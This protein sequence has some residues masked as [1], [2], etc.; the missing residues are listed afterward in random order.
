MKRRILKL[1]VV[2]A[3]VPGAGSLEAQPVITSQPASQAVWLGSNVTLTVAVAG[4]GPFAYNWQFNGTNL[5]SV[6]S[7]VAGGG[8]AGSLGDGGAATNAYLTTPQGVAVDLSGALFIADAS[9]N[10]IRKVDLNGII[11]TVAGGGSGGD[12]G[13]ATNASLHSPSGLAVGT[14]GA[15]YIADTWNNRIRM[16][17]T[18]G[19]ITTVAGNG[20]AGR[21]GDGAAATSASLNAPQGVAID[22]FGNLFIADTPNYRIRKVDGGGTITTVAGSGSFGGTGDGG[23]ATNARLRT[24]TGVAVDRSGNLFIADK[25]NSWIRKVDTNGIITRVAGNTEH[26]SGDWGQATNAGLYYPFGVTVDTCGNLY[27]ADTYDN[28]IRK[29]DTNGIIT[30]VAGCGPSE[31]SSGNYSGDGGAATNA[32]LSS[33]CSVALDAVGN[34]YIADQSNHRIRKVAG[35]PTLTLSNV[36]VK[37]VGSYAVVITGA[38]GSVTSSVAGVGLL[39]TPVVLSQ[40]ANQSVWAGSN[41]TFTVTATSSLPMGYQWCGNG[42]GPIAGGTN[43][44]LL[45]NG[46]STNASGN[47]SV[48]ITNS[49]GSIT[50][51]A[52]ALIVNELATQPANQTVLAG[53][54]L[55]LSVGVVGGGPLRFQWQFNGTNLPNN[56]ICTVA[57]QSSAG[58]SGDGG[59]ATN[60]SLYLPGR[61]Q[62]DRVGNLLIPDTVNNRVRKVDTNGFITTVAGNGTATDSGDGGAAT[63]ASLYL[64]NDV[65]WDTAGNMYIGDYQR[66]RKVN[67]NGIIAT[68]TSAVWNASG[69]SMDPSDG[70][71]I[72][73]FH[74]N[75]VSR[76][77][78]NGTLTTVAGPGSPAFLNSPSDVLLDATGN[79]YITDSGNHRVRKVDTHG[80]V[81][82]VAGN[83]QPGYSGD[84]GP[85]T[86]ASLYVSQALTMDAQGNLFIADS[87]N[88]RVREVDTNGII[89]TVAGNGT[90]LDTGDGGAATDAGVSYPWGIAFDSAGNLFV[91]TDHQVREI[92]LA[93]SPTLR[94][95]NVSL[96]NGGAYGVIIT[97]ASGSVT[98]LLATVTVH[99][100]P[101]ITGL[102]RQ[103]NGA[104]ALTFTG[105]PNSTNR[106]WVTSDLTPP[107]A[108]VP[109]STNVAG[110]DGRWQCT[111]SNSVGCSTRFYRASMR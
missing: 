106:F 20:T 5:A 1:L 63:N 88:N 103:S 71:Y 21:S 81:T 70:L 68:A 25:D 43:S 67:T 12:G 94:L 54:T 98:S 73:Q 17:D 110:A 72:A 101:S 42:G 27:I 32:S 8:T 53:N 13:M 111:D 79:L 52:A 11:T 84:G 99:V 87:L 74:N 10:R 104:V 16:V 18:N 29:V 26:Y 91:S 76:L 60:A 30:T 65:A 22:A 83:G 24:P 38:G 35:Y 51:S 14:N 92:G 15:F 90:P 105:T 108:W 46:V 85:A 66:V 102:V 7:T 64:P 61:I 75:V 89:R 33:P 96:S 56:L 40:P 19:I 59:P 80:I 3:L 50:S 49:Y 23:S 45:M 2:V 62:F 82:T 39:G 41:A 31:P 95:P 6:I 77:A 37:D 78:P 93:G 48:V 4:V 109:I 9:N 107:V 69:L 100:P 36:T 44:V 34:L 57:G 47:Y 55:I 58:F 97:S 86:N 28:R